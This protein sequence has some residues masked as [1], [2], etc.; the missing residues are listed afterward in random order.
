[1][2]Y[3]DGIF[4]RYDCSEALDLLE[5]IEDFD[6]IR[7]TCILINL[8]ASIALSFSTINDSS[9]LSLSI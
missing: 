7:T 8:K 3:C 4:H 1:M 9:F 6:I 2:T 5:F